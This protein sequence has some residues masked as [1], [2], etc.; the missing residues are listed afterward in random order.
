MNVPQ[1]YSVVLRAAGECLP[2][3]TPGK[4]KY[5]GVVPVQSFEAFPRLRVPNLDR[6]VATA[7]GKLEAISTPSD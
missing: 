4:R 3:W 1:F 5:H 7:T 6:V 2:I